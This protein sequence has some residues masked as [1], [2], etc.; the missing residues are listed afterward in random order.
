MKSILKKNHVSLFGIAMLL[1]VFSNTISYADSSYKSDIT[2]LA[3]LYREIWFMMII[4]V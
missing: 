3:I 1:P 2:M 4:L